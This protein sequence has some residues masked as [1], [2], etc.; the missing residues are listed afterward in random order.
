MDLRAKTF[1]DFIGNKEVTDTLRIEIAAATKRKQPLGHTLFKGHYGCGKTT[2]AKLCAH[3][4][5]SSFIELNAASLS[6][7]QQIAN[8]IL[9]I[10]ENQIVF[11]DEIHRMKTKLAEIF[12]PVMEDNIFTSS[13]EGPAYTRKIPPFTLIGATTDAGMLSGPLLSRFTSHYY[14]E[15]YSVEDMAKIITMNAPKFGVRL[16]Q[17]GIE[18]LAFR[19]KSVPR[20][21]NGRLKWLSDWALCRDMQ[22]QELGVME[23]A[24]AMLIRGVDAQGLER[25]DRK[26]LAALH[27][28]EATGLGSIVARTGISEET[29]KTT[30]E[31]YLLSIGFINIEPKGRKLTELAADY[32]KREVSG[33]INVY[34][35]PDNFEEDI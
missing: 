29:I 5:G 34:D 12:Y 27:T 13:N 17:S 25:D 26:Y 33:S 22:G 1:D 28:N 18:A 32:S 20:I 10:K 11:I 31:P 3:L 14:L 35:I 15:A 16:N 24:E 9:S 23:V 7:K 30:I 19:S 21:A 2:L 4:M 8:V 6:K